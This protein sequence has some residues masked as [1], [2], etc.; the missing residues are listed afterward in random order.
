MFRRLIVVLGVFTI[1]MGVGWLAMKRPDISYD[2]LESVYANGDSRFI[3]M[4]DGS[5]IHFRD[6]GPRDAATIVMVHGLTDSLH[7]WDQWTGQLKTRYR[8][9]SIDLPGHGLSRCLAD[10]KMSVAGF[11]ETIN[12]VVDALSINSFTLAGHGL[13]GNTAWNF[14]LEHGDRLDGLVLV[15]ATGWPKSDSEKQSDPVPLRLV[16][17]APARRLLRDLDQGPV[18]QSMLRA[19]YLDPALAT[20]DKVARRATLSR[21]PCHR[22][23]MLDLIATRSDRRPASAALLSGIQTPTLIM[24]GASDPVV[25]PEHAE[26]FAAAIP[27]AELRTYESGHYVQDEA[28]EASLGDLE[29]FLQTLHADD[30]ALLTKA[31]TGATN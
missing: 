23:A 8:V 5:S 29:V 7:T 19:S 22:D 14:A 2:G 26:A 17:F 13:G 6:T 21:A 3:D 15:D 18:F 24:Q 25:P 12:K 1:V 30:G 20:D 9:V 16:R 11:A 4:A 31:T 27:N 10:E 28:A